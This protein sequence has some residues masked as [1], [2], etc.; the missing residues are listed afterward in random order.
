MPFVTRQQ[1]RAH[2]TNVRKADCACS[3][4]KGGANASNG[5]KGLR[6]GFEIHTVVK[7]IPLHM[8]Q[9]WMGQALLS[10]TTIYADAIGK[11]K[12]DIAAKI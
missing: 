8:L 6:H 3:I 12:Q 9:K 1:Q 11:E 5:P 2:A 10:T 7:G 4:A